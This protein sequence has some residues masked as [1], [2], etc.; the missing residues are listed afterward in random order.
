[1]MKFKNLR[2]PKKNALESDNENEPPSKKKFTWGTNKRLCFSPQVDEELTS[3]E[4]KALLKQE[5]AKA[6]PKKKLVRRYFTASFQGRHDWI[7]E[8]CPV[9]SEILLEY[10]LLKKSR[11]V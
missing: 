6:K 10:P 8:S 5:W 7:R 1:M 4:A 2:R 3:D 11:W 9:V